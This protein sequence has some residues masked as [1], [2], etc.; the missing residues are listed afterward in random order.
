MK[1]YTLCHCGAFPG[2]VIAGFTA[3]DGTQQRRCEFFASSRNMDEAKKSGEVNGTVQY[4]GKTQCCMGFFKLVD[5]HFSPDLLGCSLHETP[6]PNA[7][8]SASTHVNNYTNCLCS[9][10]FCNTN[11]TWSP[12]T[13]Q[14][15]LSSPQ[16]VSKAAVSAIILS[17]LICILIVLV[18]LTMGHKL[19]VH[20]CPCDEK[21]ASSEKGL[22]HHCSC[23]SS[24]MLDIDLANMK[25]HKFVACGRFGL[26]WQGSY[27]EDVVALKVFPVKNHQE[28]IRERSIYALPLM[29]H[30]GIAHFF[31]AGRVLSGEFVLALKLASHGSL[32]SYLSKTAISWKEAVILSKSLVEGLAYLHSDLI[33]N[34]MHKP[35]VAH[36]DLSS[37][38]VLVQEDGTCALCDFGCATILCSCA[39][40][41]QWQHTSNTSQESVPVGTLCYMSPELLDR[42]VDLKA[43]SCLLQGD[44][45]A[46]GL[47][48]W[49]MWMCCSDLFYGAPDQEHRLPYE[50]E[51]GPKPTL[52]QLLVFVFEKRGR[53][54]I[55][56]TWGRVFQ[57]TSF[58][59]QEIL[60]DCWDHDP[61]ARLTA[62]CAANR[63][64]T[65]P[66]EFSL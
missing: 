62:H 47:L 23:Y 54:A 9:S 15:Q 58:S 31:G 25:L 24:A 12:E 27:Q 50:A 63:I 2:S 39:G 20:L 21:A 5:G 45:Y 66:T 6:C 3:P 35:P 55:P 11:M 38:N 1:C 53:P 65:L 4:C 52:E 18:S 14:L 26:V 7:T 46:L 36:R 10:D 32:N 30:A 56:S 60:E 41:G 57:M 61:E 49:E 51:L 16:A 59:L 34:G 29:V 48:L 22:V 43:G 13:K 19:R 64:A 42:S 33:S 37:N 40:P 44:V 28:F 8:C 17:L